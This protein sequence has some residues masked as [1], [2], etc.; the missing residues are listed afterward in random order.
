MKSRYSTAWASAQVMLDRSIPDDLKSPDDA[1]KD[2]ILDQLDE[3]DDETVDAYADFCA[4][5]IELPV[6][7]V[8]AL[9][10]GLGLRRSWDGTR[11]EIAKR[12][13]ELGEALNEIVWGIDR[14]Q[15]EFIEHRATQLFRMA[16]QAY[17]SK[18][19]DL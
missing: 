8:R 1:M 17:Q 5:K 10:L 12:Q 18:Q 4:D 15:E 11:S 13:P 7:L 9:I 19:G 3:L 14:L 2:N 6:E 16:E